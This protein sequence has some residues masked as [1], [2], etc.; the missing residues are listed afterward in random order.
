MNTYAN[1][2]AGIPNVA[3]VHLTE[4]AARK[5]R[6]LLEKEGVSPEIGGLRV[7]VQGGGCTCL[8]KL[9]GCVWACRAAAAPDCPMRCAWIRSRATATKSSRSTAR[10]FSW[11][12]RAFCT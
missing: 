9:A 7:G 6:A 12:P 5:I 4:R 11:T 3:A 10:A 1:K 2:E 8:R